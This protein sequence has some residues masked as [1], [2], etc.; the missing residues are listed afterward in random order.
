M[1]YGQIAYL[2]YAEHTNNKTYDGR[3]MPTWEDLGDNIQGAWEAA[4]WAV[5]R[6]NVEGLNG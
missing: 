5:L 2:G 3:E 4:A 1:T 6:R